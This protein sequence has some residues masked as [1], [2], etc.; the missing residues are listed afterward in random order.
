M[1]LW[2]LTHNIDLQLDP[3]RVKVN[4]HAKYLGQRSLSSKITAETNNSPMCSVWTTFK[5]WVNN[6]GKIYAV[7]ICMICSLHRM[8]YLSRLQTIFC[9]VFNKLKVKPVHVVKIPGVLQH[10]DES[11]CSSKAAG[12]LTVRNWSRFQ[13]TLITWCCHQVSPL[14]QW[15]HLQKP[16]CS[17]L[18]KCYPREE[19]MRKTA[20]PRE[21]VNAVVACLS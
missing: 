21:A 18:H 10:F 11:L 8:V 20:L 13:R 4:H 2:T 9:V 7:K 1:L 14:L 5:Q 3:H 6:N 15:L 17:L 16:T 12:W 19:I